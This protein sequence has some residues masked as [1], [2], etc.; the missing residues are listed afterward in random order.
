MEGTERSAR[1]QTRSSPGRHVART[2]LS[3]LSEVRFARCNH[4]QS[5]GS[6]LA[7]RV[8]ARSSE[9]VGGRAPLKTASQ[10]LFALAIAYDKTMGP[11]KRKNLRLSARSRRGGKRQKTSAKP[12][13]LHANVPAHARPRALA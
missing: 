1:V 4:P 13:V 11:V 8:R 2:N 5:V 12:E 3:K 6:A 10:K 9:D 7:A